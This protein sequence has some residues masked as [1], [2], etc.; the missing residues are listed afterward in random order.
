MR[1]V[2]GGTDD[3][4]R[5]VGGQ[6]C[7][8]KRQHRNDQTNG[9]LN[10][11]SRSTGS[12]I[13]LPY[14]TMVADVTATPMKEYSAIVV[15]RPMAWPTIWLFCERAYREKS[16]MF[17]ERV[18]QNPIMPVRAAGKKSQN[19][20]AFGWPCEKAE[21]CDSIGPNPSAR[22]YAHA[23]RANPSTIRRGALMFSR[24]RMESI[25]L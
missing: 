23:S 18:A 17:S 1:K 7:D 15:G 8:A 16:G 21:G 9:L 22:L 2:V 4:G 20:P 11:V 5:K 3:I 10:R 6:S 13:A 24:M 14:I 25:P 12:Q 19:W